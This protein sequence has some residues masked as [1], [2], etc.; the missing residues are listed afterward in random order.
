MCK[1]ILA[2]L[3]EYAYDRDVKEIPSARIYRELTANNLY[4]TYNL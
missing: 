2:I 4:L 3:A 1:T